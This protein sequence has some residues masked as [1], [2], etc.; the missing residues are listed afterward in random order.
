MAGKVFLWP[1]PN[2]LP[3]CLCSGS[4]PLLYLTVEFWLL[5]VSLGERGK[6][7]QPL[8]VNHWHKSELILEDGS[9]PGKGSRMC[10]ALPPPNLPPPRPD[11]HRLIQEMVVLGLKHIT[12]AGYRMPPPHHP[13]GFNAYGYILQRQDPDCELDCMLD[14]TLMCTC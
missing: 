1:K 10:C 5:V 6:P 3:K 4:V 9:V 12:G 2:K 11:I 8:S 14:Q 7:Q 13:Q